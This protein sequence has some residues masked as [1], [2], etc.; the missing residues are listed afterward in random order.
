MLYQTNILDN[1]QY[2]FIEYK[3]ELEDRFPVCGVGTVDNPGSCDDNELNSPEDSE[4]SNN[5][6]QTEGCS[7]CDAGGSAVLSVWLMGVLGLHRRRRQ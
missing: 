3:Y 2:R 7:G 6:T 5:A 1:D 4:D